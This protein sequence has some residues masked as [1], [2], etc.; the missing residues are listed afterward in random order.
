M[1]FE[2]NRSKAREN[3]RKHGVSFAEPTEGFTD[4]YSS[5]VPDPDHSITEERY[6]IFGKAFG[7]RHIVVAF[8]E[9]GHRIRILS[10]REM[11]RRERKAYEQ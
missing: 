7:D 8:T 11:T 1:D 4:D 6:L 10:A 2:W 3:A 5:I 9:Q